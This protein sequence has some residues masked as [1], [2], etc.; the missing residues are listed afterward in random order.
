MIHR[1]YAIFDTK[2]ESWLPPFMSQNGN[3]AVRTIRDLVADYNHPFGKHPGDYALFLVGE[4]NDQNCQYT[5]EPQP[6][7]LHNLIEL[8][9]SVDMSTV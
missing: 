9:P 6:V 3:T 4:W 8:V 2:A 5:I 1:L 7:H